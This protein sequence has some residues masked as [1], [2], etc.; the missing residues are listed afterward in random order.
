MIDVPIMDQTNSG[1]FHSVR[2]GARIVNIVVMKLTAPMIDDAP[3]R[4]R[5]ISQNVCPSGPCKLSGAYEVQPACAEP[6]RK[7]ASINSPARDE[8][9]HAECV[10][11]GKGHVLG[12][13]LQRQDKVGHADQGRDQPAG[14][15]W[16]CHAW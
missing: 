5:P 8:Q 15:S 9:P 12:P 4:I 10:Q 1:I 11:P 7:P 6:T 16:S 13:D 14:R 2:P 3:F